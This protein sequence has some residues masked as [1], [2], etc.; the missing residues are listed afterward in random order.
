MAPPIVAPTRP[1]PAETKPKSI[2]S[3][4][5]KGRPNHVTGQDMKSGGD[6]LFALVGM[7]FPVSSSLR[8]LY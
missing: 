3:H 8:L 6:I 5:S 1:A 4:P 7:A 2:V